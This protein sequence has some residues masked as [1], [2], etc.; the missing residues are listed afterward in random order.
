VGKC[1]RIIQSIPPKSQAGK[2]LKEKMKKDKKAIKV[3]EKR[4]HG[5][6]KIAL[7]NQKSISD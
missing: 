5:D 7:S 6:E 1:E 3:E 2:K 4:V